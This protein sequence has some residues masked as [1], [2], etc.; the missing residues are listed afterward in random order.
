MRAAYTREAE[1][2][3]DD[4]ALMLLA[5]AGVSSEP[6]AAFFDRIATLTD[7]MPEYLSSHPLSAGRA[8][9]IRTGALYG[10]DRHIL[11]EAEWR[12][13]RGICG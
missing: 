11:D 4:Y 3:A 8:E 7:A 5:D 10:A 13:L 2:A 1:S 9:R 12:A 6:L